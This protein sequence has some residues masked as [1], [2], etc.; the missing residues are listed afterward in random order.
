MKFT[1][2]GIAA[3][4]AKEKRYEE[5]ED[6]RTGL[7]IRV[8]PK[9]RKSFVFLYRFDGTVR[10]IT[11]GTY[12]ALGIADAHV[13]YAAAKKKLDQGANPGAGLLQKRREEQ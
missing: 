2:R 6:G 9:G 13:A 11:F 5:W 7:G 4:K 1:D 10:R 8:S 3:L 12:P